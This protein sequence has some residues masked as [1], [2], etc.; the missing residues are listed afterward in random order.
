[1]E[2]LTKSFGPPSILRTLNLAMKE[3]FEEV[4]AG[5]AAASQHPELASS[6]VNNGRFLPALKRL[7]ELN[8]WVNRRTRRPKLS[9]KETETFFHFMV[10]EGVDPDF[11][12]RLAMAPRTRGAPVRKRLAAVLAWEIKL[13]RPAETWNA[14]AR[15]FCDCGNSR[16]DFRCQDRL[17]REVGHLKRVLKKH[18]ITLS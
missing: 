7:L 6:I 11:A 10:R 14:L 12:L 15:R 16:H 1:M 17:R 3:A 18:Q 9:R 2:K 4:S 13:A 5:F 8:T